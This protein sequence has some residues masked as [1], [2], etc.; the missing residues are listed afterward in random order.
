MLDKKR[1]LRR[2]VKLFILLSIIICVVGC[3]SFFIA[4]SGTPVGITIGIIA[5]IAAFFLPLYHR[6]KY[7]IKTGKGPRNPLFV[8]WKDLEDSEKEYWIEA[9]MN[10][11][12]PMLCLLEFGILPFIFYL[13]RLLF[14]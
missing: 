14:F 6:I 3:Y 9:L 13:I 7:R 2:G 5:V 10:I 11:S 8:E 12:I 4:R 1:L